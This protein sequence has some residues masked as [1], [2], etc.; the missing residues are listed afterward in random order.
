MMI[1]KLRI[2]HHHSRIGEGGHTHSLTSHPR[3]PRELDMNCPACTFLNLPGVARCSIC[4]TILNPAP[5][6]PPPQPPPPQ[7][8]EDQVG[9]PVC[10]FLNPPGAARCSM[11]N[12]T[13]ETPP[14]L[15]AP[16]PPPP[17]PPPED[18][19]ET[20]VREELD[21]LGPPPMGHEQNARTARRCLLL[22]SSRDGRRPLGRHLR[23]PTLVPLGSISPGARALR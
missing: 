14:A 3:P 21:L 5:P 18:P 11:C 22:V 20:A 16:P 4:N 23:L 6:L 13:L 9:C 10:T 12:T 2:R 8:V 19:H 15:P 1:E 7:P 17:P